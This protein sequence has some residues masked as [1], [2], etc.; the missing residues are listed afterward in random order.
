[1]ARDETRS[2]AIAVTIGAGGFLVWWL[3]RDK[4]HGSGPGNGDRGKGE[5]AS[6]LSQDHVMSPSFPVPVVAPPLP[7]KPIAPQA[8]PE[9]TV[10]IHAKDQI[11]L[12]G[13]PSNLARVAIAAATAGL[14]IV[15]AAGDA[16][17]GFIASVLTALVSSGVRVS[18]DMGGGG[19]PDLSRDLGQAK[20][21]WATAEATRGASAPM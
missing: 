6:S 12:D 8:K 9:I 21:D 1:M 17:H 20:R 3:L 14:V 11:D 16:R 5:G 10:M 4:G 7:M 18:A 13:K 15:R 2:A 19:G